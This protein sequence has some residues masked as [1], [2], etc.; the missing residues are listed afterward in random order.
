MPDAV[1]GKWHTPCAKCPLRALKHFREFSADELDFVSR[2]K[3]GELSVERGATI[4]VEGTH[5]PHIYTVLSGLGFRYK[6]LEDG[7]RQIMNYAF[8][9]DLLG[10]QGVLMGELDHSVEALTPITLCVFERSKLESLFERH[11]SL[12]YDLTWIAAREER[13]LDEHLLSIGRRSALERTAYLLSY[14]HQRG[15]AV[16]GSGGAKKI[17]PLTQQHLADTLGLSLVHTN[18]TLRRL[19]ERRL[20]RWQ[21]GGCEVL[22]ADELLRVSGWEGLKETARP[23]I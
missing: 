11:A 6:L 15:N 1:A 17:I 21:D 14:I 18:K 19:A 2:F 9:G 4:L 3:A 20:I 7:R 16:A 12:A 8:P 13:I 10:L 22:E 23:F 5:S